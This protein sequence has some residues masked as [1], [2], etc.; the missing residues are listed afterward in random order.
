MTNH[1]SPVTYNDKFLHNANNQ[2]RRM[3]LG[4]IKFKKG[5]KDD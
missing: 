4:L 5:K 2:V 3:L 1:L